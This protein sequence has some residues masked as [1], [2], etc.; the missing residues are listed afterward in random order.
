MNNL[1]CHVEPKRQLRAETSQPLHIS[2][3]DIAEDAR[4]NYEIAEELRKY[5]PNRQ[6]SCLR[7]P[8]G[9][10][11][12]SR[13]NKDSLATW[14]LW[15]SQRMTRIVY[16]TLFSLLP[17][18]ALAEQCTVTP[19]CKP[20]GYTESSC[21]DGGGVK[22]P[23]NTSLMYCPQCKQK[24]VCQSCYVGWILNSDMT[25]SQ[26]KTSGKTPI[27]VIANQV[28]TSN[29]ATIKCVGMAVALKDIGRMN[30]DSAK[31]QC[32]SYSASG[33]TGWYLPDREELLTI[34]GNISS[35]QDGLTKAGGTLFQDIYYWS[36][37]QTCNGYYCVVIPV[38]G[39]T[40]Y[41]LDDES[42]NLYVR[43]VLA[44]ES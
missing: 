31:S 18:L 3:R 33:M 30:Q 43:P 27:G 44:F 21:P 41:S 28:I 12:A 39:I 37:S 15:S 34:H 40:N 32:R 11:L 17:T 23:W 4:F 25:C 2:P 26:N 1:N 13:S 35:V 36:S 42:D 9:V 7:H 16:L 20:L 19:D 8:E 24:D 22:C 38:R 5:N 29:G 14:I 6:L 10:T